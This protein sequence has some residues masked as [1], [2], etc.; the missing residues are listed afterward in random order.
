MDNADDC[1]DTDPDTH[2]GAEEFCDGIDNNC[3]NG[4]PPT[5]VDDDD[6]GSFTMDSLTSIG[7]GHSSFGGDIDADGDI[8][9]TVATWE[10]SPRKVKTFVN[11]GYGDFTL[12]L[13]DTLPDRGSWATLA[14]LNGDGA[15]DIAVT[16]ADFYATG[17]L[18][19]YLNA[20]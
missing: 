8:D 19:I 10:G 11:D 16:T 3:N 18:V 4:M 9:L 20:P 14:D 5:E 12:D 7:L 15:L 1:D 2:P 13:D 6:D 17:N